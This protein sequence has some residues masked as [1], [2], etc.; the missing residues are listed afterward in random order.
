MAKAA[1]TL[2]LY[3]GNPGYTNMFP[4]E[5]SDFRPID[6]LDI[7]NGM[8]YLAVD[9]DRGGQYHGISPSEALKKIKRR[10]R[11]PLT[12]DEGI[13]TVT[14]YP[15]FLTKNNCFSLLGSRFSGRLRVPAIWITQEKKPRLGW[16]WDGNPHSW[17]GSAS[18]AYRIGLR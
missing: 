1:M 5:P 2:V 18:C 7:P 8:A 6:G 11:S 17:L 13:A 10:K 14:Q 9:I 15:E 16:C 4:R 12:I 3:E